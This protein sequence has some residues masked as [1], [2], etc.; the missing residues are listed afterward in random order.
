M[1]RLSMEITL[2]INISQRIG[3][4]RQTNRQLGYRLSFLPRSEHNYRI[5]WNKDCSPWWPWI[6]SYRT[7]LFLFP[8]IKTKKNRPY[9]RIPVT[10][11]EL[12]MSNELFKNGSDKKVIV[13]LDGLLE[14][15]VHKDLT[16]FPWNVFI[17]S[18]LHSQSR[19][20]NLQH[21]SQQISSF[22]HP[23]FHYDFQLIC[24]SLKA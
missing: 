12:N 15:H 1:D 16:F 22:L 18:V 19:R 11:N 9:F 10:V 23:K 2:S 20:F 13:L 5:L 7:L 24:Q 21:R 4:I 6:E 17:K 14:I 8:Y 3:P